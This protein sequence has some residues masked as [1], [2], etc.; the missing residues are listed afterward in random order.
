MIRSVFFWAALTLGAVAQ[1]HPIDTANSRVTVYAYKSGLFSFAAHDHEI[2]APVA[3]GMIEDQDKLSVAFTVRAAEM[4]VVDPN[5]SE[6]DRAKI[7]EEMLGVKVLDSARFPEITF[8]STRIIPDGIEK[9]IVAGQLTLHGQT[10]PITLQVRRDH[11]RYVGQVKIKQRDFGI[12]PIAVAGGTIKVKD[13][14]K[15]EFSF[16]TK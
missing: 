11:D 5:A 14:V 15:I 1:P 10:R 16:I 9:W 4:K 3:S 13:E 12:Q 2:S 6:K 7:R 8:I